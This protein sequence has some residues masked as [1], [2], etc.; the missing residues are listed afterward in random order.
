MSIHNEINKSAWLETTP[1]VCVK[2]T[3]QEADIAFMDYI[4]NSTNIVWCIYFCMRMECWTSDFKRILFMGEK[5]F[6]SWC[7]GRSYK[8]LG[9]ERLCHSGYILEQED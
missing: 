1:Y 5:R 9:D 2:S 3:E 8:I 6:Q 7:K 4:D